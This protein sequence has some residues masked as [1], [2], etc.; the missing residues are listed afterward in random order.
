M[1][2]GK[3][4]SLTQ[5]SDSNCDEEPKGFLVYS[6]G[7]TWEWVPEGVISE[8]PELLTAKQEC[9]EEGSVTLPCSAGDND[10]QLPFFGFY[11]FM[12]TLILIL[13]IY[14]FLIFR[15]KNE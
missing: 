11:N 6:W 3:C 12:I 15:R 7:G 1:S 2:V 5:D 10:V 8:D 13:V 4:S 14:G 9:E